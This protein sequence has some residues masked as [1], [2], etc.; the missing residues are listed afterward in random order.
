MLFTGV[1]PC[2]STDTLCWEVSTEKTI[3]PIVISNTTG[4]V[5]PNSTIAGPICTSWRAIYSTSFIYNRADN[6]PKVHRVDGTIVFVLANI[7]RSGSHRL[8]LDDVI[9]PYLYVR[10]IYQC[11][12]YLIRFRFRSCVVIRFSAD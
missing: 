7:K 2:W 3:P 11:V 6:H 8:N 10:L 9:A 4:S 5:D 12:K 1:S